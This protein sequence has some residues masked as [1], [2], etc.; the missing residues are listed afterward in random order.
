MSIK[1]VSSTKSFGGTQSVYTHESAACNCEMKFAVFTPP[2]ENHGAGPF[3]V[4]YWLSGLTCTEENFITKSGF[5]RVAA[6]LGLVIVAPDTSPR[7]TSVPDD[8]EEAYDFGLGAGFYL[9]ATEEPWSEHYQMYDYITREL[10]E[11]IEKEFP[12]DGSRAGIFGHSMGGH[13][14]MTIHLK[15]PDKFKTCSAFAPIVAPAQVP[16]GEKAFSNYL[17]SDTTKWADYDATELVA[18]RP[19]K[20]EILIDQGTADNFLVDQLRPELFATAATKAGQKF[21]L[22]MQDGYDHSYYFISTFI[23][24][25]LRWHAAR[26]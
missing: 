7:G 24:D 1:L 23:G 22:R 19:S 15:N 6:E 2:K 9:N 12:V 13:G 3:P 4:L 11:L 18:K 16:W 14:A 10:P 26:L 5:Q 25:H 21:T 20:A 8:P 17:G